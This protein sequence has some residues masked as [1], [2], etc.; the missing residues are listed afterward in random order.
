MKYPEEPNLQTQ[1]VEQWLPVGRNRGELEVTANMHGVSFWGDGNI[2][3]LDSGD[4]C[5]TQ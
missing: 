4:G 5:T 1:K 3:E 2:L